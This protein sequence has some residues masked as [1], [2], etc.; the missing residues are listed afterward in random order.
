MSSRPA[1]WLRSNERWLTARIGEVARAFEPDPATPPSTESEAISA[2]MSKPPA[3]I[4]LAESLGLTQFEQDLL[5]L[6]AGVELQPSLASDVGSL[7][8]HGHDASPTLGLALDHLPNSHWSALSPGSPLR[9]LR[10]LEVTP[11]PSLASSPLRLDERVLHHLLGADHLDERLTAMIHP[12]GGGEPLPGSRKQ[13]VREIVDSW[14]AGSMLI[15]VLGP[16]PSDRSSV[17]AAASEKLGA[18]CY[19]IAAEDI[20]ASPS[21][22]EGLQRLWT[23]ET[24]FTPSMLIVEIGDTI[25]DEQERAAIRFAEDTPGCLVSTR[26]AVATQGP[27]KG[28]EVPALAPNERWTLLAPVLGADKSDPPPPAVTQFALSTGRLLAAGREA[29]RTGADGDLGDAL[30]AAC[31]AQARPRLEQL[32]QRIEPAATWD[33]LV[34]PPTVEK[35]LRGIKAHVEYRSL[36][37]DDW[38]FRAK[39]SRGLGIT[40]LFSGESGTGKTMAAEVLANDLALDLYR[41]DLSS[42][43]SKYIGETEKNLRRVFDAAEAGGAILLFDEA[44]ALFGKRTEVKDS[45]DRYANIE[46]SYLLQ[47]MEAYR[48][49]AILTTNL[50]DALDDAFLRRIR[51]VVRFPFPREEERDRMWR[52]IWPPATPVGNLD[53][54]R[55]ARLPMP[56]G[57]IRSIALDA[58]FRTA[59]SADP[60]REEPVVDMEAVAGSVRAEAY[61]VEKPLRASDWGET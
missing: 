35:I 9:R 29:R 32:A 26:E 39:S 14:R 56:G 38:G 10:M 41:I 19:R 59:A 28:I 2:S 18:V 27:S 7:L 53:F 13:R 4:S 55:L 5:V 11:G 22:R 57:N 42:V 20:P 51:F 17:A 49:L 12:V 37:Y 8:G 44:D 61:K 58:A 46:V 48:G 54:A 30:W 15:Q 6:T 23:R 40:A 25:T 34:V 47:R 45:H 16:D 36:V 1:R 52:S 33:D 21:E 31:Q 43:V 3:L 50:K 60:G 24:R